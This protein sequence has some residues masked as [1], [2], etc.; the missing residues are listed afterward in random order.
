[1]DKTIEFLEDL[2]RILDQK[3]QEIKSKINSI[4]DVQQSLNEKI[5][6]NRTVC[7]INR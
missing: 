5:K 7:F 3:E 1:M 6:K 4:S 2:Y